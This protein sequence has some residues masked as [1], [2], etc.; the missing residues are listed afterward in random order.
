M[1]DFL[2][3]ADS[4]ALLVSRK[5]ATYKFNKRKGEMNGSPILTTRDMASRF[6]EM[7]NFQRK[8]LIWKS[9]CWVDPKVNLI[10]RFT[11]LFAS[12]EK[13]IPHMPQM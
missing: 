7:Q 13:I 8:R 5:L 9:Y 1:L 4:L 12:T 2:S 6:R 3:K 10:A 11:I